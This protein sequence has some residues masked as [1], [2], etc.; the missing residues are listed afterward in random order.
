MRGLQD[1]AITTNAFALFNAEAR[2]IAFDSTWFAVVPAAFVDGVVAAG[3]PI[4]P[5]TVGPVQ[6]AVSI[7]AGVRLLI[8][9]FIGTGL[10]L[11]ADYVIGVP[12]AQQAWYCI[13][14]Y[15]MF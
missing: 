12:V 10:R 1:N 3:N 7:G 2:V 13:G 11:D 5:N 9:R 8:P 4:G 6:R 15:Q 14:V